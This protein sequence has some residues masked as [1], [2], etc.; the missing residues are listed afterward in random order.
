MMVESRS[1]VEMKKKQ[2]IVSGV[3]GVVDDKLGVRVGQGIK[4]QF[5]VA[6]IPGGGHKFGEK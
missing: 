2:N 4:A 3:T 5:L 1:V 6:I